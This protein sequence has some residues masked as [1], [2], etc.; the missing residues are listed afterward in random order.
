MG[1][2]D[3]ELP[4]ERKAQK[5][6]EKAT[7]SK[8]RANLSE[9]IAWLEEALDWH[10]DDPEL[11]MKAADLNY[12]RTSAHPAGW[13]DMS[14]HLDALN[15]LCPEGWPEAHF[16]RGALAY[17]NEDYDNAAL[18]FNRYLGQPES[19][20]RRSRRR[21]AKD[22]LPELTFLQ[23]YHAHAD[24]PAPVPLSEVSQRED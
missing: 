12:R 14:V 8:S 1:Q 5:L 13:T 7:D 19:R 17:I 20:T 4:R 10:P 16:L 2:C 21:E 6:F 3:P 22:I 11:H 24:R 15:E 23:Q 18:H 9:R